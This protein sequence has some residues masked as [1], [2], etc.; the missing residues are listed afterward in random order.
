MQQKQA[1][2]QKPRTFD[3]IENAL[4]SK[5]PESMKTITKKYI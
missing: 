3:N 1:N 2:T 4:T 5:Q